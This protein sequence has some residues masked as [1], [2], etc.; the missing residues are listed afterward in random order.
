[1][2]ECVVTLATADALPTANQITLTPVINQAIDGGVVPAT[3]ILMSNGDA[4]FT[5]TVTQGV[6]Y[7]VSAPLY[8][9][10]QG[11]FTAPFITAADLLDYL[12]NISK[13]ITP[14]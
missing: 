5:A 9:L 3:P 11:T 1:M 8:F 7:N 6:T 4:S 14:E 12:P 13:T 2:A 10:G